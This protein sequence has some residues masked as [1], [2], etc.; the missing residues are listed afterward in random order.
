MAKL[1]EA[2]IVDFVRTPF[3]RASKKRPGFFADVRSDDLGI[4]AAQAL[5][6]R[7]R[8][9]PASIDDIIMG[10]PTQ[11]GEQAN[12]ARNISLAAGFPFEV[13]GISVDR[14]CCSSMAGAQFAAMAIQSGQADI[15]I[16]GGLESLSH[17]GNPVIL[18]DTDLWELAKDYTARWQANPKIFE[19]IDPTDIMGL[20][21]AAETVAEKYDISREDLDQWAL[22]CNLRAAA[23]QREGKFK[24]QIIPIEIKLPDGTSE[25]VDYDQCVKP[26][27]T[28]EK[29][30]SL[31]PIYKPDGRLNAASCSKETDGAAAAMFM[32]K[33]KARELGLKPMVTI[34]SM[35]WSGIEPGIAPYGVCPVSKKALQRAGLSVGDIDL[36]ETNE[37]FAVVPLV[38]IKELGIDPEKVNVNGGAC[39]IGHPVGASGIWLLGT[40]AHEMNRRNARYGLASIPGGV[41]QATAMLVEREKY[42]K[43]R[44][45]FLEKLESAALT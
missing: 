43:G 17:F 45:A 44:A 28:I 26:D 1:R 18:P 11:I 8:V 29:I 12:V 41:G 3:G 24:D 7:T 10:T 40:M 21:L 20:G 16:S 15:I 39:G 13:A 33:E 5:M 36:W 31:P 23:A 30:R 38:L 27:S 25:L 34:R 2:V 42:W 32:S 37:A 22:T 9:N 6:K 35:A 19:R 14:A 4:I